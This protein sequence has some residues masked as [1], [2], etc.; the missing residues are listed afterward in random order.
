MQDPS[1]I[2][3]ITLALENG[4]L[5]FWFIWK[6]NLFAIVDF[7]YPKDAEK[8]LLAVRSGLTRSQVHKFLVHWISVYHKHIKY[9]LWRFHIIKRGS[10][11]W[12][13]VA[14]TVPFLHFRFL[15]VFAE[16]HKYFRWTETIFSKLN[17]SELETKFKHRI[18]GAS[19]RLTAYQI[20][21][22]YIQI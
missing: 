21:F 3:N 10:K 13:T 6:W 19:F 14:F 16:K 22:L 8:H 17:F 18:S 15:P 11:N 20:K 9:N 12:D 2:G 4:N 1:M 5:S 7:R